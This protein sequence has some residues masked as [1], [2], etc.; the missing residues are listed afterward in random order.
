[1]HIFSSVARHKRSARY[2]FVVRHKI[3]KRMKRIMDISSTRKR[4]IRIHTERKQSAKRKGTECTSLKVRKE[5]LEGSRAFRMR[6]LLRERNVSREERTVNAVRF[7]KNP[8]DQ[9]LG[10]HTRAASAAFGR[11]ATL[12]LLVAPGC[13][14]M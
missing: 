12:K 11:R 2:A 7:T 5:F 4:S 9:L 3:W 10:T 1:M 14:H 6:L 13:D 8:F